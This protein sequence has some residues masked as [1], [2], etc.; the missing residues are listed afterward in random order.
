MKTR[1]TNAGLKVK[2][3]IKVGGIHP[4]H[5]RKGLKVATNVKSGGIHPNHNRT[6]LKVTTGLKAGMGCRRNH[7]TRLLVAE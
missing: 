1:S 3:S 5:N 7:S 2:T 6:G 4:N